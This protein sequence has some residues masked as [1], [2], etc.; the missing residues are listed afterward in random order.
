MPPDG[1]PA[2][3]AMLAS[4][5]RVSNTAGLG[6][7]PEGARRVLSKLYEHHNVA[8]SDLLGDKQWLRWNVDK[9]N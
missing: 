9:Q 4:G 8:L 6:W 7:V 3:K 5:Q 2:L 1:S